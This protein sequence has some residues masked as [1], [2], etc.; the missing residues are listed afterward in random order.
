[1]PRPDPETM[2]R[3]ARE[4]SRELLSIKEKLTSVRIQR[5]MTINEVSELTGMS[6]HRI[7]EF[8]DVATSNDDDMSTARIYSIAVGAHI[9]FDV[10]ACD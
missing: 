10:R 8:E 1:M 5:K 6:A 9:R 7:S 3:V 4:N 2:K